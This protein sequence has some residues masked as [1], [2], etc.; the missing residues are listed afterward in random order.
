MSVLDGVSNFFQFIYNRVSQGWNLWVVIFATLIFF[1]VQIAF[2][3]SYAKVFGFVG[4]IYP[5]L[6]YWAKRLGI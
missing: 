3:V 6:M 4:R 1:G 5:R 2:I